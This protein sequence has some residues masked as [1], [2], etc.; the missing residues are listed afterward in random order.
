[1]DFISQFWA[2]FGPFWLNFS[3][4]D[5]FTAKPMLVGCVEH[6]STHFIN[7]LQ[8]FIEPFFRNIEKS[9]FWVKNGDFDNFTNLL[10]LFGQKRILSKKNGHVTFKPLWWPNF[11]RNFRNFYRAVFEKAR[12]I[13]TDAWMDG[14]TH[15]QD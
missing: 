15:A 10:P 5:I 4:T 11:L 13:R 2:I 9:A 1:M 3:R 7:K 14:R 8:H 6:Y 12:S